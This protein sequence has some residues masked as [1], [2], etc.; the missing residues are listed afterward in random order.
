MGYIFRETVV[1]RASAG[2]RC[3]GGGGGGERHNN[4]VLSND[5]VM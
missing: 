2:E 1:L 3:E 5:L 4:L